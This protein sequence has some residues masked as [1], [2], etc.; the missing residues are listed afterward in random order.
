MSTIT[1]TRSTLTGLTPLPPASG[2]AG[3]GG[4]LRSEWTKIR[5]VKSTVWTLAAAIIISVGISTLGNWG[6]A[7]HTSLSAAD[8]ARRD[9]VQRS[10]FGIMLGQ[11]VMVVFGALAITSEYATG[12][13]RTSLTAQP[14]RLHVYFAKL[15]IVTVIA[16]VVGEII[17]FASFLIGTH[18]WATKGVDLSLSSHGALQAVIGGGL[19]L[20]GAA[21]LAFGVGAALRHTAGTITVG[22]FLLFVVSIIVNFMP[23]S[24]Q[25]DIDKYLPANAGGQVWATQHT[26][27]VGTAFGAWAGFAVYIC[28]AVIALLAGLL[29]FKRK[30]A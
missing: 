21:L 2:R 26:A 15:V 5:S 7:S 1:D 19:Y 12:M 20:D 8:L 24:W 29:V 17:S 3:F 18:F 25:A 6:Q 27:D 10:M 13:V 28:Y 4:A 9:L 23:D 22:V 30:D 14:R 16:F 11:L